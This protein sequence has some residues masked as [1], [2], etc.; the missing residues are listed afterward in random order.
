MSHHWLHNQDCIQLQNNSHPLV[1]MT[2]QQDQL[3]SHYSRSVQLDPVH[4][5][6][7]WHSP[8]PE[9]FPAFL[10]VGEHTAS[11]PKQR[12]FIIHTELPQV[13]KVLTKLQIII[14]SF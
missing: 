12:M 10:H 11:K 1:I 8:G 9:Q 6:T 7:Q 5:V 3:S 14:I 13:N 2:A 4:P